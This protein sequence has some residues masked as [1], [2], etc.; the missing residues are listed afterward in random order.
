MGYKVFKSFQTL[1]SVEQNT[2]SQSYEILP[3]KNQ[4]FQPSLLY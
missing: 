3:Y 2:Y 4:F 1:V